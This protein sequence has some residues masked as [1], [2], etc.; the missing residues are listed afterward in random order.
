MIP[1][2]TVILSEYRNDSVAIVPIKTFNLINVQL[3]TTEKLRKSL[4]ASYRVV[5]KQEKTIKMLSDSLSTFD[6]KSLILLQNRIKKTDWQY[7]VLDKRYDRAKLKIAKQQRFMLGGGV[8]SI[9]IIAFL[10]AIK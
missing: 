6:R 8:L 2:Q 5:N 4:V 10:I 1:A 7:E 9:G 3:E